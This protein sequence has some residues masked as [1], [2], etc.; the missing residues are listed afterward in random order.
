MLVKL[1]SVA[2]VP[3]SFWL[4]AAIRAQIEDLCEA[5]YPLEACGVLLGVGDGE[6]VPWRITRLMPAPNEHGGDRRSRYLVAPTFQLSAEREAQ[7]VGEEVVGYYHSHPDCEA[8]PS[9]CDRKQ[10]WPGY[11]YLICSVVKEQAAGLGLFA[12]AERGGPF[13]GVRVEP[14]PRF[15]ETSVEIPPCP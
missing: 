6:Q 9:D 10:A 7:Q 12:L 3:S 15:G 13:Y 14:P 2:G 4:P 8:V 5:A 11:L 1:R